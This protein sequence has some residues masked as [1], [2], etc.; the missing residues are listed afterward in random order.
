MRENEQV[1]PNMFLEGIQI[2]EGKHV[3]MRSYLQSSKKRG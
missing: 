1:R 3:Q 2:N